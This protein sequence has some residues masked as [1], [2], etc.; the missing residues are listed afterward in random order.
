M[1]E[2]LI[3]YKKLLIIVMYSS[4]KYNLLDI[5]NLELGLTGNYHNDD[6]IFKK[7]LKQFRIEKYKRNLEKE[8]IELLKKQNELSKD[9]ENKINKIIQEQI[10]KKNIVDKKDIICKNKNIEQVNIKEKIKQQAKVEQANVEQ[11]NVEQVNIKGRNKKTKISPMKKYINKIKQEYR[12]NFHP[13]YMTKILNQYSFLFKKFVE[14][15]TVAIVGPAKS[16]IGT[17]KGKTIDK[18]DIVIRLNKAL[19]LPMN[20]SKD[21]GTKTTIIYNSLNV[22]DYPGQN[23]L[24][25]NLYKQY[26]VQFV[27]CSYPYNGVFVNDIN[28]YINRY[29]FDLPFRCIENGKYYA[30]ENKIKT[31]PYTGTSAI[32]DILSYNIKALYITGIDFYNTPYYSQY[33]NIS[34]RRLTGLRSNGIHNAYSQ[35]EYLLYKSLIDNRVMLDQKLQKLLYNNYFSFYNKLTKVNVKNGILNINT[36][37]DYVYSFIEKLFSGNK[38]MIIILPNINTNYFDFHKYNLNNYDIVFCLKDYNLSQITEIDKEKIIFVGNK[39]FNTEYINIRSDGK[40]GQNVVSFI[41]IF[42]KHVNRL[43]RILDIRQLTMRILF[44]M[45]ILLLTKKVDIIGYKHNFSINKVGY[46]EVMLINFF[47]KNNRFNFI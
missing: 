20:I 13:T 22:S 41:K 42:M 6:Y 35:M 3:F 40:R 29:Q 28:N 19:P 44:L 1:N 17:G 9:N 18:F 39:R 12:I 7:K 24:D 21:I 32:M 31:R 10:N 27:C 33:R 16:I 30:F 43:L 45:T 2:R 34:E 37:N 36:S 25:T 38:K 11:K 47:R 14:N 15:K 5:L 23:I 46:K 4:F 26:G 8:R